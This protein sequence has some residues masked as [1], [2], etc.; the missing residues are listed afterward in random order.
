M[1]S[2]TIGKIKVV[3]NNQSLGPLTVRQNTQAESTVRTINYGLPL[4][5]GSAVDLDKTNANTGEVIVFNAETQTFD[6]EPVVA[7]TANV[8]NT[9]ILVAGGTF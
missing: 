5:I 4:K 6:I 1:S 2:Q 8:A 9:V 3:V 7:S